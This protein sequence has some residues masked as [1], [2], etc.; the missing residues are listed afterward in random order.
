[1]PDVF[2]IDLGS[3]GWQPESVVALAEE[4]SRAFETDLEPSEIQFIGRDTSTESTHELADDASVQG[5]CTVPDEGESDQASVCSR[6]SRVVSV[7]LP[8]RVLEDLRQ[9][10]KVALLA[11]GRQTAKYCGEVQGF[12][13]DLALKIFD[14]GHFHIK[15][16]VGGSSAGLRGSIFEGRWEQDEAGLR[17]DFLL[18]YPCQQVRA[19]RRDMQVTYE[20]VPHEARDASLKVATRSNNECLEGRL[21][22]CCSD[23]GTGLV[24]LRREQ[25]LP[26]RETRTTRARARQ[27]DD[28]DTDEELKALLRP[29]VRPPPPRP[30]PVRD[31]NED[32]DWEMD[33]PTWPMYLG[34]CLFF[35]III[36][37]LWLWY[38]ENY[39]PELK[40]EFD[41]L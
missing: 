17:L 27:V 10:R 5:F 20:A 12:N 34:I 21:P 16:S 4:V 8:Q 28:D 25:E 40:L 1:M 23:E 11:T 6:A 30:K 41:E 35:V 3:T 9:P 15:E 7:D 37:F 19:T 18:R 24:L 26:E 33:E 14:C 36:V 13:A 22:T 31:W 29:Q 32:Q 39:S 2:R 38:E